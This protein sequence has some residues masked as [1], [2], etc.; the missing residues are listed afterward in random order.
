MNEQKEDQAVQIARLEERMAGTAKALEL[1]QSSIA[2]AA[3]LDKRV[4]VIETRLVA[5]GGE[6]KGSSETVA[7][8]I[9]ATTTLIALYKL[10]H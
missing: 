3:S 7:W 1:A 5:D 4:T 2:Q 10:F 6:K 8:I 9:A